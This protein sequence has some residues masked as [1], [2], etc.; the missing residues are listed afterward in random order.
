[1]KE[2]N[3]SKGIGG[4]LNIFKDISKDSGRITFI[5]TPG[6]CTPF[7]ELLSFVIRGSEKKLV[8]IPNTSVDRARSIISTPEGMQLGEPADPAADMVVL[9]GGLAI[10]KM[11]TDVNEIKKVI[12]D[13]TNPDNRTI[14][15]VFFMSIFQETGWTDVIDFDYLLDSHMKNTTLKK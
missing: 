8:F 4:L 11:N 12:D 15:G 5:G 3:V 2:I 13:I 10:P 9:L 7:A 1:M 14:I 6:F